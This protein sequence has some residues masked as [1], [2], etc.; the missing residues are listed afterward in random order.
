MESISDMSFDAEAVRERA[1][2]HI[3]T[4]RDECRPIRIFGGLEF[5]RIM[6]EEEER[7]EKKRKEK[8]REN[9]NERK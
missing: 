3:P 8:K 5:I 1:V 6:G 4:V 2:R 7:K 9:K